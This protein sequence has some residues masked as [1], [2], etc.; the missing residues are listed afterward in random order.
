MTTPDAPAMTPI[1]TLPESMTFLLIVS[2]PEIARFA[3]ASGVARLFVDLEY[4]GKDIRQKGLD[5]WKSRQTPEDVTLIR[6]A[7]PDGH[8]LVRINPLHDG[9]RAELDD[10]LARGADSIM[11]PMF[12]SADDLARFMDLLRGRAEAVP[13]VETSGALAAVPQICETLPLTRLHFGLNDLHLERKLHLMF[14]LLANGALDEATAALR[15]RDI[16]FGIGGIARAGEGLIGPE[17]LLGEHVR[18]GSDAAILSRTLHRG[19]PDLASLTASMDFP[20]ELAKLQAIYGAFRHASAEHLERNSQ[21]TAALINGV[22]ATIR[23][24]R[25]S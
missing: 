23:A 11:L 7:V 21:E 5:T 15:A 20:A 6:Q 16:R 8:L 22:A 24:K 9:T 18:L 13:L 4:M 17:R 10:V 14:E 2:D 3:H 1:P 12:Q 19:A 25:S